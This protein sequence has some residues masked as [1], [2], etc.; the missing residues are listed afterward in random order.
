V[1]FK[2][3]RLRRQFCDCTATYNSRATKALSLVHSYQRTGLTFNCPS[4]SNMLQSLG[5]RDL[6]L[7]CPSMAAPH[8]EPW[9]DFIQN[10][11]TTFTQ[12]YATYKC[13]NISNVTVCVLLPSIGPWFENLLQMATVVITGFLQ[14][15][16]KSQQ[17]PL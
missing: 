10:I 14:P 16:T 13:M 11:H 7:I 3:R 2:T 6:P 5:I 17:F 9:A 8:L 1:Y 12:A 4:T 15:L